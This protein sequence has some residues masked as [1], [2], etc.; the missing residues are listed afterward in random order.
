[1]PRCICQ[2][3][4]P[5]LLEHVAAN[6]KD[7]EARQAAQQSLVATSRLAGQREVL[8]RM[9]LATVTTGVKDRV[10]YDARGGQ[11]LPGQVVRRE[12]NNAHSDPTVNNA[13][14]GAGWT[15]DL[16]KV[17]FGRESL[18]G[19]GLRL[20]S[21]VHFGQRY[22]NAFWNGAQMCYGDGDG[23]LFGQ[24]AAV[25]DVIGHEL[26]HG[27]TQYSA[28][29]TYQGQSGALNE[30]V[31]DAFGSMVKQYT[32][33][34]DAAS[35]DWIIGQGILA[36]TLNGVGIRSM[37]EPGTAYDDPQMGRDPQPGHMRDYKNL[38]PDQDAGG[39]HINSGIPNKAFFLAA[40]RMGGYTWERAGRV[41]YL[42][43]TERL[44]PNADFHA[45]AQATVQVASQLFPG[46]AQ[47]TQAVQSA[48][49]DVGVL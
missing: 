31:S 39:V 4:P 19:Q 24:F 32:Y 3:I 28:N 26:C 9:H 2:L 12:G 48:W 22:D 40:T 23:V 5:H 16:L 1:M 47:G 6:A 46:D 10:V 15:Y 17:A 35:A 25:L 7:Q 30:H 29:L 18:D 13:Y 43:L 14:D 38:R 49:Q 41:W 20:T 11:Y 45:F 33:G 42:T 44:T 37:K 21:T 8:S 36:P 27:L 34:Q